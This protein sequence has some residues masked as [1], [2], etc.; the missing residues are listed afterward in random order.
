MT[1]QEL[2]R[3]VLA[4]VKVP[5]EF[6]STI[7]AVVDCYLDRYYGRFRFGPGEV[8][9]VER[10]LRRELNQAERVA[11]NRRTEEEVKKG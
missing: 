1:K 3:Q 5:A 9:A 2:K 8:M 6:E 11:R 4:R 10:L 7:A